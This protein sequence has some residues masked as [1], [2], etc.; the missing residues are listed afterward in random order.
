MPNKGNNSAPCIVRKANSNDLDLLGLFSS[1]MARETEGR[2]I[3]PSRIAASL[4]RV[5]EDPSLGQMFIAECDGEPVGSY[6][7]NGR[8]WTEWRNGLFYWITG[9]YVVPE[10]RC[11]GVMFDLYRAAVEWV[12]DQPDGLGLRAYVHHDNDLDLL[13]GDS[14]VEQNNREVFRISPMSATPYVVIEV[15]V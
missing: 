13:L 12:R 3:D 14:T 1:Y 10:F 4:K 6:Q 15:L 11:K 9:L 8:E 2:E 5:I 7:V